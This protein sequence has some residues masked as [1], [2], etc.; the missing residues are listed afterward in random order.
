MGTK[1]APRR[2]VSDAVLATVRKTFRD[3]ENEALA[4]LGNSGLE[5]GDGMGG[6]GPDEPDGDEGGGDGHTHIHIH[7]GGEG[8]A[9]APAAADPGAKPPAADGSMTQDDPV[10][11]RF[12]KIESTLAQILTKLGG[13]G[14]SQEP[15][16]PASDDPPPAKDEA[17]DDLP[18]VDGDEAGDLAGKGK[19]ADSAA[20]QTSFQNLVSDAEI[21]MPGYRVPTFDAKKTRQQ[22]IDSMCSFRKRIL[23]SLYMT[24]DGKSLIDG[25]APEGFNMSKA[26]CPQLAVVFRAAAGAKR[27]LNNRTSVGDAGRLPQ[28]SQALQGKVT[29]LTALQEAN[30]QFWAGR[31]SPAK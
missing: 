20:L 5:D 10:E 24:G 25:V 1:T 31:N 21:L 9:P 4:A 14:S 29:S 22:T 17:N 13:D 30:R 6:D 23:D 11:A 28:A 16:P 7:T 2:K 15:P 26:Q 19:T 12:Q 3:A 18:G 8:G 27:M